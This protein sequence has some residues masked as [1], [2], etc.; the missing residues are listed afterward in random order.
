MT[1]TKKTIVREPY[2]GYPV[3]VFAANLFENEE[4]S[5]PKNSN[6]RLLVNG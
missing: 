6:V 3:D 5:I 4:D 2:G 1:P